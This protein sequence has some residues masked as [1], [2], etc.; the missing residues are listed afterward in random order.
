MDPDANL[1]RV[2]ELTRRLS[3]P[4]LPAE[5]E[6]ATDELVEHVEALDEWLSKGGFLPQ[7]WAENCDFHRQMIDQH[8]RGRHA[9]QA[10]ARG[11]QA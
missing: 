4:Q 10:R 11:E 5:R 1:A 9:V 6:R 3:D 7:A 2:R 8:L